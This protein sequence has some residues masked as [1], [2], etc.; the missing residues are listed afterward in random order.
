[1]KLLWVLFASV[2]LGVGAV[3][4]SECKHD[5]QSFQC[6]EYVRNYDGDTVTVDIP[7]VHPLLGKKISVRVRGVDTAEVRTKEKCEKQASRRARKLVKSLLKHA[8]RIDLQNV[9]RDKY[10]RILAD[11]YV[12]GKSIAEIL[13]KNKLAV[14]YDGGSK[15]KT[16]WCSMVSSGSEENSQY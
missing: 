7:N 1:M 13:L 12:D 4:A 9:E 2:A 8:K 15:A 6:V 3:E 11:V 10:F 5:A 16:N 14:A